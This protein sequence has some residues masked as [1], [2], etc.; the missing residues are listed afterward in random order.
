M[1][2][3]LDTQSLYSDM[4][5]SR[6]ASQVMSKYRARYRTRLVSAVKI[7][8]A[9]PKLRDSEIVF[10]MISDSGCSL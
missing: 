2:M 1:N 8:R 9:D 7:Y 10:G 5:I 3:G 6:P 4:A